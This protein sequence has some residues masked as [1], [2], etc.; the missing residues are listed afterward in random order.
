MPPP[1]E[2]D[3][4]IRALMP[5]VSRIAARFIR[6]AGIRA[7]MA[8]DIHSA[9]LEGL[10]RGVDAFQPGRGVP[11]GTYVDR[12]IAGAIMD[13]LRAEDHL[14]RA[15]RRRA[16]AARAEPRDD[17]PLRLDDTAAV[18]LY[19]VIRDAR[20]EDPEEVATSRRAVAALEREARALAPRTREVLHMYYT[21]GI[22]QKQIGLHFG[23]TEP[24]I[25]QILREA[26]GHL[27]TALGVPPAGRASRAP[28]SR[29]P[30]PAQATAA[31]P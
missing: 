29:R 3:D 12:R 22:T 25:C 10:V 17:Y 6:Q 2:R 28:Y 11:P 5:R 8:D 31:E 1:A 30:R 21:D 9:G 4:L 13:L 23:L 18:D 26:H 20:A 7:A 15:D 24:R 16:R 19:S 14:S 27:R